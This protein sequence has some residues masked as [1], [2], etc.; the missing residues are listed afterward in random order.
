MV[1]Y[2]S[3]FVHFIGK[4]DGRLWTELDRKEYIIGFKLSSCFEHCI[5]SFGS[6]S[7]V[8]ILCTDISEHPVRSIFICLRILNIQECSKMSLHK[9]QTPENH[10]KERIQGVRVRQCHFACMKT[11]FYFFLDSSSV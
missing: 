10:P 4:N 2:I 5:I 3:I 7:G 6:F 9:I 11:S 8:L 1:L